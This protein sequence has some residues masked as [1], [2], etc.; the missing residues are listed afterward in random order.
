MDGASLKILIAD[1]TP[2]N[3]KQL[4]IVSRRAGHQ[5]ILAADGETAVALYQ[6]ESPDLVFMDIMMPGM[7]GIEA[8]QRIRALPTEKWTPIVF[9]SALDSMQDILRGLQAGG[10]DYLVKPA[11]TQLLQAKLN[12]YARLLTLQQKELGYIEELK[13]WRQE[14]EEQA[15]LGAHVMARLTDAEG[16]CDPMVESFNL[17]AETFSGD[18][19]CAARGPGEVLNVMLA[20]AAGHGLS[21]ALSAMPLTQ[22]FYSMTAKGFPLTSI[23]EELNRKLKAI[24][25]AD[26]FVA[27]TLASVDVRNQTVEVWNGGNPDAA[28]LTVDGKVSMQWASSHPPLGILPPAL[29][30]GVSE[31]VVFHEP[32]Q[33]VLCSDGLVE[34]ENPD[35]RWL[36]LAGSLDLLLGAADPTLRFAALRAGLERHLS[37]R[38]GRDDISCMLVQVPIERRRAVRIAAPAPVHRGHVEEWR[39][40]LT[41]SASELRYI[42]VVPAVVGIMT[43]VQALK[44]H[45][46]SLFLVISELFNNALD[47]GLLGLDSSTK[48]LIGGWEI[49]M[50]HR[51]E[52]LAGLDNGSINLSFLVHEEEDRAVLDIDVA[53]SGPGFD[54]EAWR[55]RLESAADENRT[56]GRGLALVRGLCADL[57]FPGAGN[58]VWARYL[59]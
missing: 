32:G 1:D 59:L 19:L 10:D 6:S 27:A 9:Y 22:A 33:L 42:D 37:G 40:G 12:A 25:P 26:R 7:D 11:S 24:L 2:T 8:V 36:G 29:F 16:L 54:H 47:H 20:D 55:Q 35:G 52:R 46:G 21:A 56:H 41:F 31:T 28:F 4:E 30:S 49:Y 14:A 13:S 3:L 15:R 44:P 48:N 50:Q 43:Q 57:K 53:D 51:A 5:P 39:L 23:A 38:P 18:L 58:R 34:A 45:Q 17:P